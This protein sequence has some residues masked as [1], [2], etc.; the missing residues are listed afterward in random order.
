MLQV[1]IV[2]SMTGCHWS[3]L[4]PGKEQFQ[5]VAAIDGKFK[6]AGIGRAKATWLMIPR[7]FAL[8]VLRERK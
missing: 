7:G 8:Y 5:D 4:K 3:L 1:P 6:R 2:D